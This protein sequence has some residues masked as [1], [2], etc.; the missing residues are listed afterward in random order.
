MESRGGDASKKMGIDIPLLLYFLFWYVGNYY[1]ST[2]CIICV[3][4]AL[5]P[6][7]IQDLYIYVPYIL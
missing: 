1:V 7:T 3:I 4:V 5:L 2:L 6:V